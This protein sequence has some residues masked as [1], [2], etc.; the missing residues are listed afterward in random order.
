MGVACRISVAGDRVSA[1]NVDGSPS[2]LYRE[3]LDFTDNNQLKALDIWSAT[4]LPEFQEATGK[5]NNNDDVTLDEALKHFNTLAAEDAKLST[6]ERYDVE[7]FMQT[8]G[9]SKLSGLRDTLNRI[10]RADGKIG[11][12]TQEAI[13]SG[14]YKQSELN[15]IDLESMASMLIKIDGQLIKEDIAVEPTEEEF[16]YTKSG[17]RTALGNFEKISEEQIYREL[18]ESVEDLSSPQEISEKVAELGYSDFAEKFNNDPAF[19]KSVLDRFEGLVKLPLLIIQNGKLTIAKSDTFSTVKNTIRTDVNPVSV[20]AITD[21]LLNIDEDIW[22]SSKNSIT[23]ILKQVESDMIGMGIDVIGLSDKAIERDSVLSFMEALNTLVK[24]A[25][26]KNINEKSISDF[27]EAHDTLI[28]KKSPESIEKLE[29]KYKGLTI[30]KMYTDLS[31]NELFE[32][33][34]LIKLED[35]IY[36]KIKRENTKDLIEYILQNKGT[37]TEAQIRKDISERDTGLDT[38]YSEEISLNQIVFNHTPIVRGA[39]NPHKVALLEITANAEY[40][41]TDFVSDFYEEILREKQKDSNLYREK[42]SKFKITDR[43]ITLTEPI[44]GFE[45][46]T[47]AENLKD[48]FRLKKDMNMKYLVPSKESGVSSDLWDL[49][50]TR[51]VQEYLGSDLSID[52]GY[53]LTSPNSNNYIKV[54]GKLYEKTIQKPNIHL[55]SEVITTGGELYYNLDNTVR[56]DSKVAQKLATKYDK[57]TSNKSDAKSV[58]EA[59][60]K[61]GRNTPFM[62]R[63]LQDTKKAIKKVLNFNVIGK[64]GATNLDNQQEIPYRLNNLLIAKEMQDK[65]IEGSKVKLATGWEQMNGEWM[66]EVEDVTLVDNFEPELGKEYNYLDVVKPNEFTKAYPQLKNIKIKFNNDGTNSFTEDGGTINLDAEG[67]TRGV[68]GAREQPT[69]TPYNSRD[70]SSISK[71]GRIEKILNHEST[72]FAQRQEGFYTGG[73]PEAITRRGYELAGVQEEDDF[74]AAYLKVFNKY[75]ESNIPQ[76]DKNILR[77]ILLEYHPVQGSLTKAYNDL[78]GEAVARNVE[79]RIGLSPQEKLNSLLRDTEIDVREEDKIFLRGTDA[80]NKVFENNLIEFIRAKGVSVVTDPTEVKRVLAESGI[81][82]VNPSLYPEYTAARGK[83]ESIRKNDIYNKELDDYDIERIN[84]KLRKISND[85]GANDLRLEYGKY[86]Y[87]IAD[88]RGGPVLSADYTNSRSQFGINFKRSHP[89]NLGGFLNFQVEGAAEGRVNFLQTPAGNV[90][91]FEKNG[92]IYLDEAQLNNTTTVHELVH[93]FQSMIDIKAAKGDKKAQEIIAKRK[94]VFQSVADEWKKFHEGKKGVGEGMFSLNINWTESPEGKGDKGISGR[95]NP[96][97]KAADDLKAGKISNEEYRATL[98]E[99][100]PIKPIEKF[101]APPTTERI[102]RSLGTK[103]E[104]TNSPVKEN[105][106]V[107]L[108]LDIPSY[109]RN[110]TWVV[111]VHEGESTTGTPLSYRSAARIT[112]VTFGKSPGQILKIAAGGEKLSIARIFGDWKNLGGETIEEQ[113]QVATNLVET[114]ANNKDWVQVGMNPFRHSYF[115]DRSSDIG[116]PV[117]TAEE[118]VQVGGLVYAKNVVYGNWTDEAYRVKNLYDSKGA[119][120]QFN[121]LSEEAQQLKDTLGLDLSSPAYAQRANESSEEWN[122]RLLKEV[123]AYVTAPEISAKLEELKNN[124]PSLWKQITDFIKQLTDW[125]KGQIGLSDYQGNIMNMSKEEYTSALGISVLKDD[126]LTEQK[127]VKPE[128]EKVFNETP[129][130][131]NIGTVDQYSQYLD[132]V[133]PEYNITYTGTNN[134]DSILDNGFDLDRV[135]RYNQ[136]LGINMTSKKWEATQ[137]GGDVLTIAL[138]RSAEIAE[139]SSDVRSELKLTEVQQKYLYNTFKLAERG[140]SFEE[141]KQYVK[142]IGVVNL[143]DSFKMRGYSNNQIAVQLANMGIDGTSGIVAGGGEAIVLSNLSKLHILGSKK[144]VEGF[145]EFV[146]NSSTPATES[147]ENI[148]NKAKDLQAALDYGIEFVPLS[149][150]SESENIYDKMNNCE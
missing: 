38:N 45:G 141:Y 91:G 55:Y 110:N 59:V 82:S 89:K 66:Y 121:I 126:Y 148:Q 10:F 12:D 144:D 79:R 111:S 5:I 65:G 11:F 136:G 56:Y 42:L 23:V 123:E 64:Q 50:S 112:N 51:E 13:S 3:A 20:E 94:D 139:L 4:T 108:R 120:V 29:A 95:I 134:K 93:V 116:R 149:P 83:L 73:S 71:S 143:V 92:V 86:G 90:L 32:K 85:Y 53:V 150:E 142:S 88:N 24:D 47:N 147:Y 30:V 74:N 21:Y 7:Q 6:K 63:L 104:K 28:E 41:K 35:T 67:F 26:D 69:S 8:N 113:G 115:Y 138:D 109:Q 44:S 99:N 102:E 19:A 15:G 103:A 61:A 80:N 60:E 43:D 22:A 62:S 1:Y 131:T 72:H 81:E 70:S 132:T 117:V 49:N 98:S 114:I 119:P 133:F 2:Q 101:F 33:H 106:R 146:G 124:D 27:A 46:I 130:L 76:S 31:D 78:A 54:R 58:S 137:Y 75:E 97:T 105:E 18:R 68:L 128:V 14:L 40:L 77:A 107:G 57:L 127:E 118:V 125:L 122:T 37:K 145:K 48:Y 34:G 140:D 17:V 100:S 87:Y 135:D 96:V 39:T 52:S 84:N 25:A 16:T 36:H 129:E 9:F